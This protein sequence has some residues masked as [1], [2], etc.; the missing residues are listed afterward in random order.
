MS[1]LC[2]SLHFGVGVAKEF[3]H[4]ILDVREPWSHTQKKKVLPL[5]IEVSHPKATKQAKLHFI[6]FNVYFFT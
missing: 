4:Q 6:I 1:V 2:Q 3:L 5:E